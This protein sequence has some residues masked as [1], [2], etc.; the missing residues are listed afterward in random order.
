[1]IKKEN[2]YHKKHHSS[3]ASKN[4]QSTE[5]ARHPNSSPSI[6]SAE[7]T[8]LLLGKVQ[9]GNMRND[10]CKILL[11]EPLRLIDVEMKEK[12]IMLKKLLVEN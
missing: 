8:T 2:N 11:E 9:I 5:K 7:H 6:T 1:M 10:Q 12:I 4:I 3:V